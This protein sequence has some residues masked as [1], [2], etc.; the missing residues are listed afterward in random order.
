MGGEKADWDDRVDPT[1]EPVLYV[2]IWR[3][4]AARSNRMEVR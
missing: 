3:A 1:A 4:A 2:Y